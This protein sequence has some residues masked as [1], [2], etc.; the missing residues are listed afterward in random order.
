MVGSAARFKV[1]A[2]MNGRASLSAT[3]GAASLI[4]CC[5]TAAARAGARS[6][7]AWPEDRRSI[8]RS[9]SAPT[10]STGAMIK[11][12]R[13]ARTTGTPRL[14]SAMARCTA[15]VRGVPRPAAAEGKASFIRLK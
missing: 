8:D 3:A 15:R 11:G 2:S 10:V 9:P 13:A 7:A 5:N 14:A 12:W 4:S 1:S 6:R